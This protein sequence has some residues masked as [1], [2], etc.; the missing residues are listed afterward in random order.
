LTDIADQT[1]FIKT[2]GTSSINECYDSWT[3]TLCKQ[4]SED[5]C[6]ES[7][8]DTGKVLLTSGNEINVILDDP[9]ATQELYVLINYS[10]G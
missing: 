8:T 7:W 9:F 2:T 10:N 5:T 4:V 1:W 3:L 6:S